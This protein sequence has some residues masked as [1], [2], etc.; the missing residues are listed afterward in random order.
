MAIGRDWKETKSYTLPP[1]EIERL[2]EEDY[3][4][5]LHSVDGAKLAEQQRQRAIHHNNG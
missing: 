1:K 5:K 2:L 4:E 3:G